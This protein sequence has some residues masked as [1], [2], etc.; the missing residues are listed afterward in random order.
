MATEEDAKPN[1]DDEDRYVF[2]FDRRDKNVPEVRIKLGGIITF[3]D[4]KT[5]VCSVNLVFLMH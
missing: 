4:F 2:V 1:V 3:E 5:R